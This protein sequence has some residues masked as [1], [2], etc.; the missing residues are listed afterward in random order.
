MPSDTSYLTSTYLHT[1]YV[2]GDIGVIQIE[3]EIE[4]EKPK[5]KL[6]FF[7]D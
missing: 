2:L 1:C 6:G 4:E 5:K 7:N 3:Y